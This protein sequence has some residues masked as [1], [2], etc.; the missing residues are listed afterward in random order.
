MNSFSWM[1]VSS[2][3]SNRASG[4][5]PS[6]SSCLRSGPIIRLEAMTFTM[7]SGS[8]TVSRAVSASSGNCGVW[9]T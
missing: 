9:P 2:S 5:S 6:S 4:S 7:L 8:V 1:S 3:S